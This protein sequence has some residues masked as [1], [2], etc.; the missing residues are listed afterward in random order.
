MISFPFTEQFSQWVSLIGYKILAKDDAWVITDYGE[1]T[2]YVDF[3]KIGYVASVTQRGGAKQFLINASSIDVE[4][5]LT[6]IFGSDIR[7]VLSLPDI[8]SVPLP[9]QAGN[10]APGYS[11]R[12]VSPGKVALVSTTGILRATIHGSTTSSAFIPVWFSWIIDASL[13]EL[14]ASYLDPN[15][16]PLFPGCR[17]G[18]TSDQIDQPETLQVKR[19]S[20]NP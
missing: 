1:T 19:E 10:I 7:S 2:Y 11:L 17:I 9:L 13:E 12:A 20:L 15:G 14:R 6:D 16:L 4:R 8:R 18:P 3:V 5:F